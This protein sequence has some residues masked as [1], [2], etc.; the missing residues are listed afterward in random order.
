MKHIVSGLQM[1]IDCRDISEGVVDWDRTQE[2]L[3]IARHATKE[4]ENRKGH[5]IQGRRPSTSR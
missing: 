3:Q 2:L 5:S 1:M 4:E